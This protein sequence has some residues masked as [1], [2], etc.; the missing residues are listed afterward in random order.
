MG[1]MSVYDGNESG[2]L[3]DG[4]DW[5]TPTGSATAAPVAS[6]A[7]ESASQQVSASDAVG[8]ALELIAAPVVLASEVFPSDPAQSKL[9]LGLAVFGACVVAIIW[10]NS[11]DKGRK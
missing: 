6:G 10:A 9:P 5:E 7:P 11:I 2:G 3:Y 4:G 1:S 8:Q